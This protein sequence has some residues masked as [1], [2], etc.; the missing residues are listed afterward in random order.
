MKK[1]KYLILLILVVVIVYMGVFKE[2]KTVVT[3]NPYLPEDGA[4]A[5]SL[6]QPYV[7]L[8]TNP[9]WENE[10]AE[11]FK[12]TYELS[13]IKDESAKLDVDRFVS[14][15]VSQ[16][17][18]EANFESLSEGDIEALGFN[19]GMKYTLDFSFELKESDFIKSYILKTAVFTGG[20][21][22]N[23]EV[24]SFNYEKETGKRLGLKDV[25]KKSPAEYLPVLSAQGLTSLSSKKEYE[26]LVSYEGLTPETTNWSVWYTTNDSLN[27]IFQTYQVVPYA[28]GTP[29]VSIKAEDIS[30]LI[31]EEYFSN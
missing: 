21:H 12:I 30:K 6:D 3:E 16:F 9:S 1:L 18:N 8:E 22:G 29:E 23:L 17:K 27:F 15:R 26:G 10:E 5:D 11:F 13:D 14:D 24:L 2:R 25:F 19:R 4:E 7:P 28:Y 20:A 31:N